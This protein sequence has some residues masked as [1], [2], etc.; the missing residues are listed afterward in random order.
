M[1]SYKQLIHYKINFLAILIISYFFWK[2]ITLLFAPGILI[3]FFLDNKKVSFFDSFIYTVVVSLSWW[4]T[5]FWLLRIFPVNIELFINFCVVFTF[6]IIIFLNT[7]NYQ[8]SSL[9]KY[10]VLTFILSFIPVFFLL[11]MF[12]G[13]IVPPG[14][15][16]ATHTYVAKLIV[17]KGTFPLNYEPLL[18]GGE[19]GSSPIGLSVLTAYLNIF[20]NIPIYSAAL[21]ITQLSYVLLI[22]G[23]FIFVKYYFGK[24]SAFIAVYVMIWLGDDVLNYASWG[25]NT[26]ILSIAIL[27]F[28]FNLFLTFLKFKKKKYIHSLILSLI[29][30]AGFTTHFI[31]FVLLFY[32]IA[33]FILVNYKQLRS[34]KNEINLKFF[35]WTIITLSFFLLLFLTQVKFP[36]QTIFEITRKWHTY[37]LE[38]DGN[39]L[40]NFIYKIP[41]FFDTKTG[42]IPMLFVVLGIL[43]PSKK[44]NRNKNFFLIFFIISLFVILNSKYWFL[45]LS[46]ILFPDR[47]LTST[48]IPMSYFVGSVTIHFLNFLKNK[49]LKNYTVIIA[50]IMFFGL[51][52]TQA[53]DKYRGI[54]ENFK[55]YEMVT[56][57]DLNAMQW[58]AL[59]TNEN[60]VFKNNYTDA[61]IWIPGISFR[62][63]TSNDANMNDIEIARN[64]LKLD[65]DYVFIGEKNPYFSADYFDDA[66]YKD[67]PKYNLVFTSGKA[68]IYQKIK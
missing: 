55:K 31:P 42:I 8:F 46:P 48:I 68:K 15:D 60:S 22:L 64:N 9:T 30:F 40:N 16:M 35:T 67:N 21:I 24:L 13:L 10:D 44:G 59:N 49:L 65:Y 26:T 34:I 4:I 11:S 12:Q 5:S 51:S 1:N 25:G 56:R 36:S 41:N 62:K 58:I 54:V 63:I 6:L 7:K 61:G 37:I 18:S 45:P 32:W 38:L 27:I 20:G 33:G 23:L 66:E 50:I 47:V 28:C 43:I 39:L 3:Y 17:E 53:V 14:A 57:K 19:F 52:L 2:P 29:L